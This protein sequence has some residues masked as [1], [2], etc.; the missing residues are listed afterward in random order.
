[1][2][3]QHRGGKRSND[4]ENNRLHMGLG[5]EE[6]DDKRH[7]D[8]H[9][10]RKN[11]SSLIFAKSA[12]KK[13]MMACVVFF[14]VILSVVD[15]DTYRL[16]RGVVGL[17]SP[18]VVPIDTVTQASREGEGGFRSLV[19]REGGKIG[20]R[21]GEEIGNAKRILVKRETSDASSNEAASQTEGG[22]GDEGKTDGGSST[23][24]KDSAGTA[25]AKKDS[26]AEP[27]TAPQ[28]R[29]DSGVGT[30]GESSKELREK[31]DSNG[32]KKGDGVTAS[33]PHTTTD[34]K[35]KKTHTTDSKATGKGG[36]PGKDL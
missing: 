13:F 15:A 1:M 17:G 3:N 35:D 2:K 18:V 14:V 32:D 7:T 31:D 8:R 11:M 6:G 22:D 10:G 16:R 25:N 29:G 23:V 24:K 20:K 28:L 30:E 36:K 21:E 27:G 19:K 33:P 5:E 34:N 9:R 12:Q 4:N 26:P